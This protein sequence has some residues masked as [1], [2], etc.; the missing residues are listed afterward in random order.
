MKKDK[1][2]QKIKVPFHP[3]IIPLFCVLFTFLVGGI[4]AALN[5]TRLLRPQ[6][7][8]PTIGITIVA[9]IIFLYVYSLIPLS[10]SSYLI[11]GSYFVFAVIGA[12]FYFIQ[13]PYYDKWKLGK[14]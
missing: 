12:V 4:V 10:L 14:L 6:W 9:F 3:I 8:Y 5:W 13:K 11:Y 7:K 2:Q 1:R